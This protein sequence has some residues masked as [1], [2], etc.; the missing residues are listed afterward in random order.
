MS[1]IRQLIKYFPLSD[2][3]DN[4]YVYAPTSLYATHFIEINLD[5]LYLFNAT[6]HHVIKNVHHEHK[7]IKSAQWSY[8]SK[9]NEKQRTNSNYALH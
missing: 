1:F 5:V 7:Q 9:Q 6:S 8:D 2:V 3:V 4:A